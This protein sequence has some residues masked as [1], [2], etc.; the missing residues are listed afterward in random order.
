MSLKSVLLLLQMLV[1]RQHNLSVKLIFALGCIVRT[2]SMLQR[3]GNA[4]V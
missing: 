1:L 2:R 4:G 3:E